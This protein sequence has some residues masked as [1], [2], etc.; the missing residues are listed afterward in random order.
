MS[1]MI[2][3]TFLIP[4]L[5]WKNVIG[6]FRNIYTDIS[7]QCDISV[8]SPGVKITRIEIAGDEMTAYAMGLAILD[9]EQWTWF[10][11][12]NSEHL[13]EITVETLES[14]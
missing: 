1:S 10:L 14:C 8:R 7:Q 13:S 12:I 11:M 6:E 4:L 9:H 2:K 3:A 5:Q